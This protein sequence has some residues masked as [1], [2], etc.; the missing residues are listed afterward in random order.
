MDSRRQR[1]ITSPGREG[2]S[3]AATPVTP[4]QQAVGDC[5]SRMTPDLLRELVAEARLAPGVHNIQPTRW[6]LLDN[7][8]LAMIDDNTARVPIAD[9]SNHDVRSHTA[10]LWKVCT[11]RS[12]ATASLLRICRPSQPQ[13]LQHVRLP[14][15]RLIV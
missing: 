14:V 8:R 3:K 6:R 5:M 9:P 1:R 11:S 13:K 10:P 7:R 4:F 2:K 12:T 15:E